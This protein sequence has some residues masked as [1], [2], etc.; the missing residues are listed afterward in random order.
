M[1]Y[2]NETD[3]S[4]FKKIDSLS[5]D[6]LED[7]VLIRLVNGKTLNKYGNDIAHTKYLDL[8]ITYT[9]QEIRNEQV[10]SHMLTNEEIEGMG[11]S[12]DEVRQAAFR[13]TGSDRKRRIFTFKESVLKD[14]PMFPVISMPK[15]FMAVSGD[16]TQAPGYIEDVDMETGQE[17]VLI[18]T[19]RMSAFGSCYMIIPSMLE[20]VYSRFN[21]ENFYVIPVSV[22]QVMCVR[23]S[24]A[25]H[26]GQKPLYE[27]EDD[28]LSMVE[29]I[30]DHSNKDW[31]DILSYKI[32]YYLGDD[33][34]RLFPI[35]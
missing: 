20:E 27:V 1:K 8:E 2:S 16:Q 9:V 17:N 12:V 23:K 22:H 18:I 11:V 4:N 24:Y 26:N 14:N 34:K 32:Y 19:N 30:N 6:E 10:L 7:K 5:W 33:G 13:N 35:T 15:G 21:Q 28:L 25:D 29:N 3:L 31:K